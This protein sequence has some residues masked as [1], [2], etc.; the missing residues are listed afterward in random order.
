MRNFQIP[1]LIIVILISA[2]QQAPKDPAKALPKY[3]L[4]W[5][6]FD[7]AFFAMDTLHM[8]SSVVA[9]N[10]RY[11]QFGPDFF[12]KILML[13]SNKDTVMIKA[14]Y[15]AYLPV[16]QEAVK[17][18]A[19]Q[20]SFN[21]FQEAFKRIHYYFPKYPLTHQL[22]SFIG[23]LESY[24]N[25]VTKDALA[26]GLQMYMGA[27]SQWYF[28]ERI[29]T[30]YPSFVS[31]R[32]SH[33]YIVVN[34]VQNIINDIVPA[35]KLNGTLL[36]ELIEAG[37]RQYVINACM[38]KAPDSVRFGYTPLQLNALRQEEATI[39]NYILHNKI[40]YSIQP[41][42]IRSIIQ[43]SRFSEIFGEQ[44]PGNVG[45]F[46]GYRIV[47]KWMNQKQQKDL[48]LED[49]LNTPSEKIFAGSGY[50]P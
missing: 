5:E 23:P 34:S 15:R 30:I 10:Q 35:P 22:I 28:S 16:Y 12:S 19:M 29:Q 31:K 38:P 7:S 41:N 1:F 8:A 33:E 20:L 4:S 49:L 13:N 39:W 21:S 46:I 43:E 42:E 45:K 50:Q 11:P 37:K 3:E 48:S 25:I 6:K 17:A 40:T 47:E 27:A 26:L 36:D 9:L 24:G 2:C 44:L 14:F 18:R 32:F